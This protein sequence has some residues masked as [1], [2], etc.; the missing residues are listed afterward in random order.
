MFPQLFGKYVLEGELASGGM[1]RV[2]L[3]TLR[4][5]GGFEKRLVVKQI[6]PEFASDEAFVERFVAEAK[7]AVE[8]SHPNILPVYE[9]GVEN[10]TYYIAM[11]LC[12]G[13][14]LGRLIRKAPLSPE[15]GAYVG[16][17]LCRALEY[18]HRKAGIVHRDITPRNV[19]VDS[20]GGVRLIDFGIVTSFGRADGVR[21]VFGS[22]GHM[23][24]EQFE[25]GLLGPRTDLFALGTVLI[26]CW[27]GKAPFRRATLEESHAA[28]AEPV[29]ALAT[30][31]E[32]LAP[33]D[34]L[35]AQTIALDVEKR[36]PDADAVGRPL[37]AFLRDVDL[38]DVARDLGA[39][40]Q[41][42]L[43]DVPSRVGV[44]PTSETSPDSGSG[45]G[46]TQTFA[47]REEVAVW[48]QEIGGTRR[49]SDSGSD[50]GSGTRP[51]LAADESEPTTAPETPA[52]RRIE[53]APEE[54]ALAVESRNAASGATPLAWKSIGLGALAAFALMLWLF[55][56][57]DGAQHESD[58]IV[59]ITTGVVR[60]SAPTS[61]PLP[62]VSAGAHE[63]P[64]PPEAPPDSPPTGAS[65]PAPLDSKGPAPAPASSSGTTRPAASVPSDD[66]TTQARELGTLS[67]TSEPPSEV[68]V[69]GTPRGQTP[70][71]NLELPAGRYA[72]VFRNPTLGDQVR[73]TVEVA[74]GQHRRVHADFT[75]ASPRVIVR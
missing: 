71:G 32:R 5:A 1:A 22:P 45:P 70:I 3:A 17:E 74:A 69:A 31:D 18:A 47:A 38:A 16:V 4:G 44:E 51:L 6:R 62:D 13:V 66:S 33:L 46:R 56:S 30:M 29:P 39:R 43:D 36:P 42:L 50:V 25:N 54:P 24:P 19:M 9:L 27:T 64:A 65:V 68:T 61:E 7:T 48:S 41:A 53:M 34:A 40:V 59:P 57:R 35:M 67:M 10:G 75:T 23:P 52:T 72:L 37:R 21:Q 8:L 58:D 73:T 28:L 60:H 26:E 63:G 20:E 49:L 2:Y 55:S 11:E 15:A 14:S 12:E